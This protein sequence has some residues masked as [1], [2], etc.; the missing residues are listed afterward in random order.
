MSIDKTMKG[1]RD[2]AAW[3][4]LAGGSGEKREEGR[5]KLSQEKKGR[6]NIV[7]TFTHTRMWMYN[8]CR[9]T[10]RIYIFCINYDKS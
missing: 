9:S 6:G 7:K 3:F 8:R 5:G 10:Q 2:E 4:L 1:Y